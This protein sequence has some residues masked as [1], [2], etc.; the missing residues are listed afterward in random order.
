M[1]KTLAILLALVM[2]F[3]LASMAF[4]EEEITISFVAA[5]YSDNTEPYLKKLCEAFEAENPNVKIALEVVPW[6]DM[7]VKWNTMISAGQAPDILNEGSYSAFVEDELLLPAE[8]FL[9][10]ELKA[11]FF[12]SFYEYNT[13]NDGVIYAIPLLASVRGLYCNPEILSGAG[14]EAI[15]ETWQDVN[16]ACAKIK[17]AYGDDVYGFGLDF[18]TNEG[19][20]NFCYFIWNNG[21]DFLDADGNWALNSEKNVEGLQWAVDLFNAGYTNPNPATET[22]DDLQK[23]F[24][25]GKMGMLITANFFPGLYPDVKMDVAA[26]PHNEGCE[27]KAMGVQ[28]LLMVFDND[29]SEEKLAA[30]SKFMDFFYSDEYYTEFMTGES[31]LPATQSGANYLAE[32]DPANETYIQILSSANFYPSSQPLWDDVKA[33]VRDA[34]QSALI[35]DMTCQEALD[36]LQANIVG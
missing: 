3:S 7:A 18:T 26:I 22:R 8:K 23:V 31:M 9:S 1:K 6:S 5:Q 34:M 21:S 35:G 24:A 36:Q 15:P 2:V 19:Q 27:S 13:A 29:Y 28:D 4:A 11:N 16:D 32:Q 12:Q 10:P 33:G 14:V 20:A 30:I 25:E 17:E